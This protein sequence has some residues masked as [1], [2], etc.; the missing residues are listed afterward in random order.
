MISG[1]DH[2]KMIRL[3]GEYIIPWMYH[4]IPHLLKR[5]R[6]SEAGAE[7]AIEPPLALH[8]ISPPVDDIV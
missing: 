4:K 3:I 2:E 5:K 8:G 7:V 6:L 1:G